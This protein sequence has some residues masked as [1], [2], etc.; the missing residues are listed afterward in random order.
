MMENGKGPLG[1]VRKYICL[2]LCAA[3]LLPPLR[4]DAS[5]MTDITSESIQA[6]ESQISSAQEERN[7][8]QGTLTD[9]QQILS[10]LEKEK[11]D[12]DSYVARLDQE[13]NQ[14]EQTIQELEGKIRTKEAEIDDT[15][16]RLEDA[17]IEEER[18]YESMKTSISLIYERGLVYML[19]IVMGADSFADLLNR[20]EYVNALVEYSKRM[21]DGFI[22]TRRIIELYEEALEAE[23]NYLDEARSAV[24]E[25]K[26][27]LE[28]LIEE[29]AREIQAYQENI[30][31]QAQAVAEYKADIAARNEIIAALEAA[32][33]AER[34]RILEQNGKLRTYDGGT[35]AFPMES[36][37]RVSDD[38]GPRI[39][40]TLHVEQFHNG[41]DLTA[42]R[43]TAIYAA[44]DG[45]V[46]AATYS[47]SMGNYV[48]IDHG[49]NLF[50][51]YM[52]ASALYVSEG[53]VVS[54][55]QKIAAV[56]A[57]GRATGNHLHF[58]VRKNGEYVN[59]WDYIV[60]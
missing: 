16:H 2:L 27:S 7:A 23:K 42:P 6:I 45:V 34:R 30:S 1:R 3:L 20:V 29:K 15:Q 48:M 5:K 58:S 4:A 54:K 37:V 10:Q 17:R 22:A 59:P 26:E 44:Y 19:D 25:E 31:T 14:M 50:T 9:L 55:G 41:V 57:T 46:I 35:F 18:Q 24:E 32:A 53:D 47:Q 8:L 39:H 60:K 40:P 36:Y 51:I 11:S 12:L 13:L 38:Y 56:G 49:D 52:H 33:E 43:G 28:A 21:L